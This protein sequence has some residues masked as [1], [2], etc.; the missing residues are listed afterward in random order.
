MSRISGKPQSGYTQLLEGSNL[1]TARAVNLDI[2][3]KHCYQI[4][5]FIRGMNAVDAIE[6]LEKVMDKKEAIP[7]TRRSRKGKGETPW[8]VIEKERWD[9]VDTHTKHQENSSN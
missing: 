1:A 9:Q 6:Y 3:H 4:A 7:Y 8:P 2:H 5:K